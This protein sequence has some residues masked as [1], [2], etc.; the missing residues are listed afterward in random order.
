MQ[1]IKYKKNIQAYASD[2]NWKKSTENFTLWFNFPIE[3][4]IDITKQMR[5]YT[6]H[7]Y[8]VRAT[9]KL[10]IYYYWKQVRLY[11]LHDISFHQ[12]VYLCRSWYKNDKISINEKGIFKIKR[13][14]VKASSQNFDKIFLL[15][16]IFFL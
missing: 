3:I 1:F 9:Y 2:L 11:T 5:S 14:I 15:L 16:Y 6:F 4:Q 12:R 8:A 10:C 7:G 13:K